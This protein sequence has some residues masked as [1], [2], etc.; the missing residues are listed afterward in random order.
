LHYPF[1]LDTLVARAFGKLKTRSSKPDA[2]L[3][4]VSLYRRKIVNTAGQLFTTTFLTL[5]L[6]L[7]ASIGEVQTP[8]VINI[9]AQQ[10]CATCKNIAGQADT[11]FNISR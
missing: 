6:N 11:S 2:T 5:N 10:T 4:P 8:T 1:D 3:K 7:I 9:P